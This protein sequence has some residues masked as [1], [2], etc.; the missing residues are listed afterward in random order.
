M[1]TRFFRKKRNMRIIL[2][3]VALMIIPGF[4][5]WGINISGTQKR[6]SCAAIVDGEPITYREFYARLGDIE[7]KYRQIFGDKYSEIRDKLNIERGVL[8]ELI[9][10]KLL[11]QMA[12]KRRI[13]VFDNEIVDA[14]KSD[15]AFKDKNG[16]FDEKKYELIIKRMPDEELRKIEKE[17][18]RRIMIEKLKNLVVSEGNIKVT[19]KD[20]ED[21]I[22]KNK[23]KKVDKESVRKILQWQKREKYFND[24]YANI[25]K[26]AKVEIFIPLKKVEPIKNT[27]NKEKQEN[28]K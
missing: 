21:Y 1:L 6:A 15:P 10:E 8:E 20:V 24:W 14:V 18:K 23:L 5:I 7:D 9:R 2:W 3:I 13:R 12:R 4:L 22:K 28:K 11:L 16:K 19:D 17:V 27:E 25:R 26:T